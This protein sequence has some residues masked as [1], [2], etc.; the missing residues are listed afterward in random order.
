[1]GEKV[2]ISNGG[3]TRHGRQ[4]GTGAELDSC[5][6]AGG[7]VNPDVVETRD[8]I[9][10]WQGCLVESLAE[11]EATEESVRHRGGGLG[12]HARDPGDRR[13]VVT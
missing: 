3:N 1:M 10:H 2:G 5:G 9:D 7:F 12:G 4:V 8:E 6:D 13:G 11:C